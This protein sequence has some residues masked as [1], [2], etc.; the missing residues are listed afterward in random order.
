MNI[1]LFS[2]IGIGR[3]WKHLWRHGC[4]P[5]PLERP[6]FNELADWSI[7]KLPGQIERSSAACR[8]LD[9]LGQPDW[10]DWWQ[11]IA[12]LP[13]PGPSPSSLI[14]YVSAYLVKLDRGLRTMT[15]LRNYLV[16]HPEV[17]WLLGFPLRPCSYQPWGFDI[18]ASVPPVSRFSQVLRKLENDVLQLLLTESI[19]L[20]R[21]IL[22][23]DCDF[24]RTISLDTKHIVAWVKQNNP[25]AYIKEGRFDKTRQPA[26]DKD[27]RLGY[28]SRSNQ[29]VRCRTPHHEG[30]PASRLGVSRGDYYWGYAS[31]VV[32]TKV[33]N[34]GEFVLA[35]MTETFDQSDVSY[36][37]PLMK[38]VEERLGFAPPNGAL[39]AAYD[40]HYVYDYFHKAGG[41]AAVPRVERGRDKKRTF[42]SEG[43]PLCKAHLPMPLKQTFMN[44]TSLVPHERGRYVCPLLFP[45]PNGQECPVNHPKWPEGGCKT[46]MA[47]SAGARLRHQLDR[48]SD[49]Y[50][51]IYKQR[52]AVERIFSQAMALG[53]ERPKLRNQQ[54]ITN[55]NTLIYILINLRALARL[56][57]TV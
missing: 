36:F 3:H 39:D 52:T 9:L 2:H 8:Y 25:K 11:K 12:S 20:L 42:S 41:L 32:A 50:K 24:G 14:P 31:G 23:P 4:R 29:R 30:I 40:A 57:A 45:E 54:S 17:V 44:R 34:Y 49:V 43:L 15:A 53:I 19:I 27:C 47:T 55:Q 22:P 51:K 10:S 7:E 48:D 21:Q 56:N 28:K 16:M 1:N 6:A 38:M 46:T 37:H 35:E 13:S 33:P 26:G 18:Q 5:L